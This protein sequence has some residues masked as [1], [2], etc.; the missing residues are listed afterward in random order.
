MCCCHEISHK[1]E[2]LVPNLILCCLVEVAKCVPF[3]NCYSLFFFA[4]W[5]WAR[6]RI[7]N[8]ASANYEKQNVESIINLSDEQL[9]NKHP[10]LMTL[11]SVPSPYRANSIRSVASEKY[12]YTDM[13]K[14]SKREW[15]FIKYEKSNEP[16]IRRHNSGRELTSQQHKTMKSQ[17]RQRDLSLLM[18]CCVSCARA[19]LFL[20]Y[21][22]CQGQR[23]GMWREEKSLK[24]FSFS[25]E[26]CLLKAYNLLYREWGA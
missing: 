2:K 23:I 19:S 21:Y 10:F 12:N 25:L 20:V 14:K 4:V 3:G 9:N 6:Y 5:K 7:A 11:I 15:W 13:E 1:C 26:N 17:R 24:S 18:V 8:E 16:K 22:I